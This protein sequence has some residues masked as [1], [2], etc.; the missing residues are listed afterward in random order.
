MHQLVG[1]ILELSTS[2]MGLLTASVNYCS[3]IDD[4]EYLTKACYNKIKV[5]IYQKEFISK[6]LIPYLASFAIN[7]FN[8]SGMV[9]SFL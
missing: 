5:S 4:E 7:Y 3:K 1:G 6:N 9:I 8:A 2:I